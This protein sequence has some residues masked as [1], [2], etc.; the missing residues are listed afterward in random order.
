MSGSPIP[1]IKPGPTSPVA[2]T[3]PKAKGKGKKPAILTLAAGGL[4]PV[5]MDVE[6]AKFLVRALTSALEGNTQ[7]KKKPKKK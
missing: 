3:L 4:V 2:G 6:T 5:W 1:K 7:P